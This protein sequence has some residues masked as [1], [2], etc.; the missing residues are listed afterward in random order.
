MLADASHAG[1]YNLDFINDTSIV[2]IKVMGD[3]VFLNGKDIT[4]TLSSNTTYGNNSP[5]IQNN[6]NSNIVVGEKNSSAQQGV[7]YSMTITASFALTLSVAAYFLYQRRK[8]KAAPR[9]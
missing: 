9:K 3:T 1:D 5:I 7:S 2:R 6:T 4:G 8:R